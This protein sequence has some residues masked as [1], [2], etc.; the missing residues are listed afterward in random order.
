MIFFGQNLAKKMPKSISLHDVLEPLKQALLASRDVII[1]SQI[2]GLNL[3]KVFTLGD[4]C[5]L[6]IAGGWGLEG[7][8]LGLAEFCMQAK[9]HCDMGSSVSRPQSITQKGVHAHTADSPAAR[10]L[11]FAAF[12]TPDIPGSPRAKLWRHIFMTEAEVWAKK[13]AKISVHFRA[14]FGVQNDPQIFSPKFLTQFI[15]P[16]LVAEILKFHLPRASGVLGP[17]H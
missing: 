11:V 5:W 7:W 16:C 1:S 14:A 15:T 13:W 9:R 2:C 12:V 4:G 3:Q 6:P 17:Q 10:T 8:G